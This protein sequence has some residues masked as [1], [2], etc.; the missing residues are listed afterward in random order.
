METKLKNRSCCRQPARPSQVLLG[1][2]VGVSL[3]AVACGGSELE[4]RDLG[5]TTVSDSTERTSLIHEDKSIDP[6]IA[7]HWLGEAEDLFSPPGPDGKRPTY[8]FPSGSKQVTLDLS[9]GDPLQNVFPPNVAGRITFGEGPVPEP[10]AG[11]VYPPGITHTYGD[12]ATIPPL[13]GFAYSLLNDR[14][15]SSAANGA[16]PVG[17][18]ATQSYTDWCP[19]QPARL[20][21]SGNFDCITPLVPPDVPASGGSC[22]DRQ[23]VKD[24]TTGI[25]FGTNLSYDCSLKWLCQA[26][27][28]AKKGCTVAF[29]ERPVQLW[30][31]RSGEDLLGNFVR[32]VFD[33]GDGQNY[34]PVGNVRFK[35]QAP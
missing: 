9:F 19:L 22:N 4:Q 7:G 14:M 1:T 21:V 10:T 17:Y 33:Y 16:F 26:C 23:E 20:D 34:L 28:C 8:T 29:S 27:Q 5:N 25:T 12:L 35:R 31:M 15:S 24:P 11:V 6:F 13:E 18:I 30:L 32:A 3:A 2:L